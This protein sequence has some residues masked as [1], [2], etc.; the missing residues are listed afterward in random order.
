MAIDLAKAFEDEPPVLDFIWPGF[1]AGTV[2]ALVAPGAT[3]KSYFTLEAAMSIACSVAGG[4]LVKLTPLHTGRVVYMAGEDPAPALIRRIH[5]IGKHL[6]PSAREAIAENLTLEP[7]MGKR[8]NIMD[9]RHLARLIE[10]CADS[11]L[12]VLDTLSR[13]HQLDE[14]SNGDMA[15]LVGTL[16]YVAATTGASVL[17]LHHVSKGSAR[18]GQGDQQQ[19]ARGASALID[20]ARWCGFVAKMTEQEAVSLTAH[21]LNRT[22]IDD[23]RGYFIRFGISKQNYDVTPN[24][25]W[26]Q[27]HEGGVLFPIEL[28][29]AVSSGIRKGGR[30]DEV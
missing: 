24:D 3:G 22:P 25:R 16:E 21:S 13:I 5:A 9:D 6:A 26:Y 18:E 19:A 4:D 1:L 14:N 27:R 17:Y 10:Y 8:L 30:R 23:Q 20:N 29:E 7:I 15:K 12:I 2:G 11:R 28:R